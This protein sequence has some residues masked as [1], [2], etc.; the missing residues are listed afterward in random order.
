[1]FNKLDEIDTILLSFEIWLRGE[2]A[3]K[4]THARRLINE[5]RAETKCRKCHE[6]IGNP[7]F[8]ICDDC[9]GKV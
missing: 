7:V 4:A 9:W 6:P 3:K 5:I 1:M 2:D 8:T